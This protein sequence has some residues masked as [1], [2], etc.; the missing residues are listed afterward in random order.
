MLSEVRTS[1]RFFFYRTGGVH[2]RDADLNS[3]LR[4]EPNNTSIQDELKKVEQAIAVEKSKACVM[5]VPD[6][7]MI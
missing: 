1:S 3:A 2:I 4:L 7:Y 6:P 5:S